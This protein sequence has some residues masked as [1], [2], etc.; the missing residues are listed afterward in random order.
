ML[1]RWN[2]LN[3]SL[4]AAIALLTL[5]HLHA[6]E[7][8]GV[9]PDSGELLRDIFK[10][11]EQTETARPPFVRDVG[12]RRYAFEP[13][14]GYELSGLVVS[15]RDLDDDWFDI[16]FEGDPFNEK[17]LCV[18]WGGNLVNDAYKSGIYESGIWTCY[19]RFPPGAAG[20]AFNPAELSNNHVLPAFPEVSQTLDDVEIG[21]QIYMRGQ[22]VSYS[23]DG[24]GWRR[25]SE[26]R[27]DQ[28]DR[29]CEV[30]HVTELKILKAANPG[31]RLVRDASFWAIV[32]VVVAKIWVFF[33]A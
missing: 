30:V 31:W 5:F 16:Y 23:V 21:D 20:Q 18:V 33:A 11:P 29:A 1:P 19:V 15:Q 13:L 22:L 3:R 32:L 10:Q 26:L 27:T 6:R 28:G 12:G 9:F 8:S 14:H 17:D 25:S 7:K 2:R 24:G 4:W